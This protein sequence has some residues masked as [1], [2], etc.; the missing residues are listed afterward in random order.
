MTKEQKTAM[1]NGKEYLVVGENVS[2]NITAN[3]K[4]SGV[5]SE[6][7]DVKNVDAKKD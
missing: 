1:L 3:I 2:L 4:Q 5:K 6:V 7:V